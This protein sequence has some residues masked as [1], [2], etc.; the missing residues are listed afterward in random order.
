MG[1]LCDG[2][3]SII[4]GTGWLVAGSKSVTRVSE[5]LREYH[6]KGESA[7]R[8]LISV[9]LLSLPQAPRPLQSPLWAGI[10]W[11]VHV[12]N[13]SRDHPGRGAS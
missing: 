5:A 6:G 8:S 9:F 1:F 10:C 11:L 2:S 4:I 12:R 7:G 3:V 13:F